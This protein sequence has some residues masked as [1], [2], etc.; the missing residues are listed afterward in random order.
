[1]SKYT[2]GVW[3]V[4]VSVAVMVGYNANIVSGIASLFTVWGIAY[5]ITGT[6]ES[7]LK[8]IFARMGK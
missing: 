5:M 7:V 2:Y 3:F 4:A 8:A 1:M 6:L